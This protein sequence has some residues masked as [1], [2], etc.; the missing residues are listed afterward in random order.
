MPALRNRM[1]QT[2]AAVFIVVLAGCAETSGPQP[3]RLA[4][5]S[6]DAVVALQQL[7]IDR[8]ELV[9]GELALYDHAGNEVGAV[10]RRGDQLDVRLGDALAETSMRPG[11]RSVACN[12]V[13]VS[14]GG[15]AAEGTLPSGAAAILAPCHDAFSVAAIVIRNGAPDALEAPNAPA[16]PSSSLQS[17]TSEWISGCVE[18]TAAGGCTLS[19]ECQVFT[20]DNG[21][22]F[23]CHMR[24]SF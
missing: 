13:G 16:D 3:E 12:G 4:P 18:W 21:N 8:A 7:G 5:P 20:C 23:R 15:A 2:F 19:Q 24:G 6:H 9:D 1:H 11:A 22:W 10:A 17:C 14:I